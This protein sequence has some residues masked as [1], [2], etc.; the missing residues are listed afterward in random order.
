[1][2]LL[3]YTLC[4]IVGFIAGSGY[5]SYDLYDYLDKIEAKTQEL[6][7]QVKELGERCLASR[8]VCEY[9]LH[10]LQQQQQ[11]GEGQ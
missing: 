4:F 6:N 11:Q 2:K 7:I 5:M 9:T 1:M 3:N 8:K 10:K